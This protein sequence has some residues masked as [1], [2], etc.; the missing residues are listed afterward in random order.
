[1]KKKI[2]SELRSFLSKNFMCIITIISLFIVYNYL[3]IDN[4]NNND[5]KEYFTNK[6]KRNV[7]RKIENFKKNYNKKIENIE[8]NIN[9]AVR[10][11]NRK[12]GK[13]TKKISSS[14]KKLFNVH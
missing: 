7:R 6:N 3:M 11:T 10:S 8:F 12:K 2:M 14:F 4:S 1:M 9:S 13:L 5:V